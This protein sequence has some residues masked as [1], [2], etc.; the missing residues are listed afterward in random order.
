MFRVG[1][2]CERKE[3]SV[4]D[5]LRLWAGAAVRGIPVSEEEKQVSFLV[6]RACRE[7]ISS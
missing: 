5:G 1:C 7:R 6:G 4:K 2:G 3:H